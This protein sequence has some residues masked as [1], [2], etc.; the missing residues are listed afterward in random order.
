MDT[1]RK[2][3]VVFISSTC[4]DLKQVRADMKEF[5]EENYGFEAMLSE[6]DSFP[7]D[8]CV[9][10]F[11]NC[12]SNVDQCADFFVLIVGNRYGYVL[13]SGK[14]ITN[15]EYLHAKAKGIPIYVFVSKQLNNTLPIWKANKSGDYSSVVDNPKIF[16]FVAEIKADGRQWIYTYETVQDIKMT[17]K[18][19]LRLVFADGLRFKAITSDPRNKVLNNNLPAGAVRM[20]VEKPAF[21]EYKFLAY[22]MRDEFDKLQKRK[23]DL[24]YGIFD[25]STYD[26]TPQELIDDVSERFHEISKMISIFDVLINTTIQ[27]AI[28]EPGVPSDLEMMIYTAKRVAALYERLVSWSLYFKSLHA[29]DMFTPLLN[30]LYEFPRQALNALDE[31]VD[32]MYDQI[33][34]LP[35]V[36]DGVVR[37]INLHVTLDGS[38]LDEVNAE[39]ERLQVL[40]NRLSA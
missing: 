6:F 3:P 37:K 30:L 38:N 39:I 34:S 9:G 32:E 27:E 24:K 13:D 7:I 29:D 2:N 35:D 19:Q 17:L 15:L 10:T 23:W 28:A 20:V 40:I 22:V 16:E 21:W 12:L 18:N 11:E 5:F 31:F 36:D 1:S 33:T 25:G 14:S 8:P 4:Y 26:R